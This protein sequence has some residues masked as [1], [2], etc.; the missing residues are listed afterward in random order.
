LRGPA[1]DDEAAPL[2]G[3]ALDEVAAAFTLVTPA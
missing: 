2:V 3:E 1:F